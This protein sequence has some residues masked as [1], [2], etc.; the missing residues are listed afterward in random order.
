MR[1]IL[2]FLVRLAMLVTG[3]QALRPLLFRLDKIGFLRSEGMRIGQGCRFLSEILPSEP[4]LI[5]IKDR[6]SVG[7]GV[8]L[9]THDGAVWTLRNL[10]GDPA[11]DLFGRIRI[12]ENVFIGN[13][14]IVLPNVT[15]GDNVVVA[16][17][18]VVTR[19]VPPG[20]IAAGVPARVVQSI[21]DYK[22]RRL[23]ACVRTKGLPGRT[24][25]ALIEKLLPAA[26]SESVS[27]NVCSS[28]F[29]GQLE[30]RAH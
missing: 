21:E 3:S 27:A 20:S 13:N 8:H 18:A 6:V 10:V 28:H 15:I 7:S 11:L 25:R 16:A 4:Y 30:R 5:E 19:D 14:A 17:G 29:S 2:C 24:R 9:I 12:G 26:D 23:P 22:A 1:R